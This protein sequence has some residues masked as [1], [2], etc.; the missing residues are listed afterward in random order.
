[1]LSC[2]RRWDL[3]VA[4]KL[5][6]G[7]LERIYFGG[8]RFAAENIP[9][10]TTGKG[11]TSVVPLALLKVSRLQPLRAKSLSLRVSR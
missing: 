6:R 5:Q 10:K 8:E 4:Q 11:T 1:M 9:Q 2:A 7:S 3:R